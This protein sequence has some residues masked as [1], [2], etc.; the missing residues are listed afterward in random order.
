MICENKV[1][2]VT[3]AAGKGIGR[4]VALTLAREGAKVVINYRTSQQ[5]AKTIVNH[6][7]NSGDGAIAVQADVFDADGCK[8]LVD[9]TCK[10]FGQVDICIIGPGA[11]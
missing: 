2:I 4:S 1:A 8:K 7:V 11:G 5:S 10:E 9:V 6:I 3:G